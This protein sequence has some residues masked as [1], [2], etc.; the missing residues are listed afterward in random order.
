MGDGE[1][2]I[3]GISSPSKMAFCLIFPGKL[4]PISKRH[5]IAIFVSSKYF[6]DKDY[7]TEK[8]C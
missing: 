6:H 7:Q 3:L 1:L 2:R 4:K 5:Q 8:H